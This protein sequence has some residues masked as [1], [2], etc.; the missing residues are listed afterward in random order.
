MD[1]LDMEKLITEIS[2]RRPPK[3]D[4][5]LFKFV[6]VV[7]AFSAAIASTVHKEC[8]IAGLLALS[9]VYFVHRLSVRN[10][11]VWLHCERITLRKMRR[12]K[13]A[14]KFCGICRWQELE[15]LKDGNKEPT[16]NSIGI[17]AS[18]N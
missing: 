18:S 3:P 10:Y 4:K 13:Y 16:N 11:K 9:A 14:E 2:R 8:L 7:I 17:R 5:D 12:D 1:S 15:G 6:V